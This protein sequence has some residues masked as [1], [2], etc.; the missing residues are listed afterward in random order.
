MTWLEFIIIVTSSVSVHISSDY[1]VTIRCIVNLGSS[2][3]ARWKPDIMATKS[4]HHWVSSGECLIC[5]GGRECKKITAQS[6]NHVII[7]SG[8]NSS[9]SWQVRSSGKRIRCF[10]DIKKLLPGVETW[11]YRL[12]HTLSFTILDFESC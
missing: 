11:V 12:H 3:P 4:D 2:E 8:V 10:G 7:P 6:D 9:E 5:P 1:P